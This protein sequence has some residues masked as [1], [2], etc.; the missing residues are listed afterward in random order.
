MKRKIRPD[1]RIFNHQL[2]IAAKELMII[3]SLSITKSTIDVETHSHKI[4][5]IK[6]HACRIILEYAM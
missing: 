1:G 2:N 3:A 5:G 6:H 4:L